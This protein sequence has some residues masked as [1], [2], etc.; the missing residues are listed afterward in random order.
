MRAL[1]A[2]DVNQDGKI[3]LVAGGLASG[4]W[5]LEQDSAAWKQTQIAKDSSGFE[6][7][8]LLAD[9]DGDGALEIY[10]G[11]EDQHELRE[12]EWKN[13]AFQKTV[14]APLHAGDITWNITAAPVK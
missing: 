3:D 11:S 12:Y 8:V 14:I 9:L 2:G 1:A 7:P 5:L 13:G 10:V 4:L 6:Q